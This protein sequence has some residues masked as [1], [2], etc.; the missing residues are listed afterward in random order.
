V[1]V[2]LLVGSPYLTQAQDAKRFDKEVAEIT[3]KPLSNNE[4]VI[5]FTGSSTIKM[6]KDIQS[7]FPD[8]NIVNRGFGGSQTSDLL[9]YVDQLIVSAQPKKIFIYEGDNDLGS[10]K[11]KEQILTDSKEIVARIRKALGQVPVV[12]ITPKPSKARWHLKDQY[13]AYNA[14]LMEWAK[15]EPVVSVADLWTPML[16][17]SGVVM[18][19]IFLKDGLHMNKK[20]YDIWGKA[21]M[22]F[23]K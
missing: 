4:D 10:G 18:Q 6:W 12:F 2:L 3:A 16:D 15:N 5:L 1:V 14:A 9:F 23:V 11:S 17:E 21:L 7:Y 20:G 8:Q 19:D 13:T 22:P